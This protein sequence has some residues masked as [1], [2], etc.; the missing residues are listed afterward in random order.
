M[1]T[2]NKSHFPNLKNHTVLSLI[3]TV[4]ELYD[5]GSKAVY[6]TNWGIKSSAFI[7]SM[8]A[9]IV[10]QAIRNKQL[11]KLKKK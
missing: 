8:Q 5:E 6:H 2:E 9:R 3:N 11:F 7:I 10:V 1:S 4:E